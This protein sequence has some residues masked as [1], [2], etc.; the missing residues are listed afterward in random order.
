MTGDAL[1]GAIVEARSYEDAGGQQRL[2]LA[3]R[4]D[5]PIEEQ[6]T[7]SGAIWLDRQLLA[8][9]P[10]TSGNVFGAEVRAAMERRVDH[11][12]EQGLARRASG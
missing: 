7:A 9:E 8:K 2:S 11:L 6:T 12:A 10:A 3:T 4:S 5:L 1:P